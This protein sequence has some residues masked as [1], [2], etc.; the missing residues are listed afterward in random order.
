VVRIVTP[1]GSDLARLEDTEELPLDRQGQLTHLVEEECAAVGV[2]DPTR[3]IP[4]GVRVGAAPTPEQLDLDERLGQRGPVQRDEWPLATAAVLVDGA[5]HELL[6]RSRLPEEEQRRIGRDDP[7]ETAQKTVHAAPRAHDGAR[8]GSAASRGS[9][10]DSGGPSGSTPG[11]A[12]AG[13]LALRSLLPEA[14]LLGPAALLVSPLLD[15]ALDPRG[16]RTREPQE[17]PESL[18][19]LLAEARRPTATHQVEH[20]SRLGV[21]GHGHDELS[22]SVATSPAGQP[23]P[24]PESRRREPNLAG[25]EPAGG[26][27]GMPRA[28]EVA[29]TR[30]SPSSTRRRTPR[31]DRVRRMA[32]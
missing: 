19:T 5:R 21:P 18:P 32:R 12:S 4:V 11:T 9:P 29:S 23:L 24:A 13:L 2:P 14:T 31:S 8:T 22:P 7:V 16:G 20:S 26:G 17:L 30:T 10:P 1:H 15:A 25:T 28:S 27:R 3:P 6:A